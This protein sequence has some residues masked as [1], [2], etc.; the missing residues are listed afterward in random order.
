MTEEAKTFV[1][2]VTDGGYVIDVEHPGFGS[3]E[4]NVWL[5]D[6]MAG[7]AS[8]EADYAEQVVREA[9]NR[10]ADKIADYSKEHA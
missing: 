9:M 4:L 8:A 3:L 6:E 7:T 1:K 2:T 5:P 10:I